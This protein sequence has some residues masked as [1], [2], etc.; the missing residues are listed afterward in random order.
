M[1]CTKRAVVP[2]H[3]LKKENMNRGVTPL[4]LT[5]ALVG[6]EWTTSRPDHLNP[7]KE[8]RYPHTGHT[9]LTCR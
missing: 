5:S 2:V 8:P 7:E 1:N 3:A 4:N 6:R 9:F